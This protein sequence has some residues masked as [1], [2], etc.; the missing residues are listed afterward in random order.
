M[1]DYSG[2]GNSTQINASIDRVQS[3]F[4]WNGGS[5]V[6]L[7]KLIKKVRDRIAS[8]RIKPSLY[9]YGLN[10]G[11]SPS[12]EIYVDELIKHKSLL[13]GIFAGYNCADKIETLRQNETSVLITKTAIEQEKSVLGN[14]KKEQNIYIGVGALVLLVGLYIVIKK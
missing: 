9:N 11:L 5:C 3:E 4:Y 8:E 1:F 7:D 6:E 10:K 14:S 2:G 12:V 13:E